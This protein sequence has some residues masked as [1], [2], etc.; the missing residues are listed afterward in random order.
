MCVNAPYEILL[1][2]KSMHLIFVYDFHIWGPNWT[3]RIAVL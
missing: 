2:N 1:N 3:Q